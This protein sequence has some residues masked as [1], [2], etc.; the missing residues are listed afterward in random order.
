V[1]RHSGRGGEPELA[2]KAAHYLS[3][4]YSIRRS[5]RLAGYSQGVA[6]RGRAAIRHSQVL[7]H[8]VR[9]Q[10]IVMLGAKNASNLHD[11]AVRS[12]IDALGAILVTPR[13]SEC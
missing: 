3:C 2:E 6:S 7:Q 9:L 1:K 10:L 5:L 11:R 8:A 13:S 4:G 12:L